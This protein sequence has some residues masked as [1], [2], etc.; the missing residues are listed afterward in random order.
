VVV[1]TH[2]AFYN[3]FL[4]AVS[5]LE[6][7]AGVWMLMNNTGITRVEFAERPMVHYHNRTAHLPREWIT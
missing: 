6:S 7:V 5:G 1:V 2:G 3:Y 4:A